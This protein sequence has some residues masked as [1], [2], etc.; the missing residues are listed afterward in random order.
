MLQEQKNYL[1]AK[2]EGVQTEEQ[3]PQEHMDER[4]RHRLL[5]R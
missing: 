3:V 2:L 1:L 4:R 5:C